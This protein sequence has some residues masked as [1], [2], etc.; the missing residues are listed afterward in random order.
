MKR[1][2][3]PHCK[4]HNPEVAVFCKHCGALFSGEPEYREENNFLL[5]H[6]NIIIVAVCV[7]LLL[8]AFIIFKSGSAPDAVATT[9]APTESSTL[10]TTLPPTTTPST[11]QPT[12]AET[13]TQAITL[14][15]R[16]TTT[17]TT[18]A[19]PTADE[20]ED[21]CDE[22]NTL[23]YNL[24]YCEYEPSIHK[25]IETGL[26]ITSFSLPVN[27]DTLNRFMKNLLPK[28]NETYSFSVDGISAE[29]SNITLESY[30]PPIR[31]EDASVY[32]DAVK[33][34]TRDSD[35]TIT[36]TF[37]PDSS[38]FSNGTT[39]I[40]PYVSTA[41]EYLDFATFALGPVGITKAEVKYPETVIKAEVD[42]DGD[43]IKL[44]IKQPVSVSC[45]GG[46]GSLTADVGLNIDTLTVFEVTY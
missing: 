14:P 17:A 33:S 30:I 16:P 41:T 1:K 21:I 13:T 46:V 4:T 25:S 26:E 12:T 34:A 22:Y 39:D 19:A 29:N 36:L 45:T 11:T 15:T 24:K 27:T 42:S 37:K 35:G 44:S 20:I 31:G 5:K 6:R 18:T 9:A 8:V 40:P 38:T 28:T 23:I 7:V 43:I 3:C 32:A 2:I 10:P